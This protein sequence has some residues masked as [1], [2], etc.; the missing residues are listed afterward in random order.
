MIAPAAA[1]AHAVMA[2]GAAGVTV[3]VVGDVMLDEHLHGEVARTSPEAPVPVVHVVERSTGP[4][5]AANVARQLAAF[6]ASVHLVGTVGDDDPGRRVLELCDEL[7]I[8]RSG[9]VAV[10]GR[11]TTHKQRVLASRQQ[12]VR[13]DH[14]DQGPLPEAAVDALVAS[15]G[16]APAPDVIVVSDYAKGVVGPELFAAATARAE[17]LGVPLLVDPKVADLGR[18]R[19]ATVIKANRI[20]FEASIG[21]ALGPDPVAELVG[22]ARSLLEAAGVG[23]LVVTLGELGMVVV[24]PE[25]PPVVVE[26][27]SIEVFDVS[28]AG[29]T[30]LAVLALGAAVGLASAEAA[31]VAAAAAGIVVRRTGVAVASP[32]EVRRAIA[33][34][35]P[36]V[37]SLGEAAVLAAGWRDEGRSIVF[38][39]GCFDLFHAGHLHLVHQAAAL[40]EVLVVGLNSDRSVRA[41]KGEARP[42]VGETDR[43]ALLA[44]LDVVDCVVVFDELDPARLVEAVRP[45]VLVKGGDY[46]PE[47]IVGRE[48]V[49]AA[50]GR[51]VTVPLLPGW[52]TTSML[53]RLRGEATAP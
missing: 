29:D 23:E 21:R 49:E 50:G 33:G 41:L 13:I 14:E 28:G 34:G 40:G 17:A 4:G 26:P 43:A 27:P 2:D 47:A 25:G 6:G 53:D 11:P 1:N 37:A 39:N 10:A 38:T 18:Y 36:K 12:L 24:G 42:L 51:V 31:P 45:D 19:G 22:P 16:A 35:S 52:S 3:L 9:M 8:D 32:A 7:G 15:V 5:G 48:L 20:E 30:V 46:E 44:A